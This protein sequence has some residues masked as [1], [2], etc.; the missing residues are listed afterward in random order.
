MYNYICGNIVL[1][2]CQNIFPFHCGVGHDNTRVS[3]ATETKWNKQCIEYFDDTERNYGGVHVGCSTEYV[4]CLKLDSIEENN[5][6][7]IKIDVEGCEK[8]VIWGAKKLIAKSKPYIWIEDRP[9]NTLD[10]VIE[11][12]FTQE[13]G[14]DIKK[15]DHMKY[16]I[17]AGY[18]VIYKS[19]A[20]II[21]AYS[22][23]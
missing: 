5:V 2:E 13:I 9:E 11:S 6:A 3:V 17:D 20:D 8:L 19:N 7:M 23:V 1:N 22:P 14:K 4:Q 21:L 16:I 12:G 15:F 18:K 10:E